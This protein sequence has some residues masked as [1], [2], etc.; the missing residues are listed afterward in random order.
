MVPVYLSF[1]DE[2]RI[3]DSREQMTRVEETSDRTDRYRGFEKPQDM[4]PNTSLSE[5]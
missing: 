3:A 5:D 1:K 4:Q 2:I